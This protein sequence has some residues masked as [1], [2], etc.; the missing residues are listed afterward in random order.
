MGLEYAALLNGLKERFDDCYDEYNKELLEME[1]E[2]LIELASEIVAIK[3][4]YYEIRFWIE[5]SMCKTVWSNALV[6]EP[7]A[8]Q[9]VAA[10]L[11]LKNPLIELGLKW[12]FH[13]FGN[14]VDFHSFFKGV[15]ELK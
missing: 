10:L 3:E 7:I 8:E 2:Q 5:M 15:N 12:W 6:N 4:T 1:A 11:L 14:K 9:D 13:S